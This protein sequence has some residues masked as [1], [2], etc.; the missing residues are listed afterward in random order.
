MARD[1]HTDVDAW[2]LARCGLSLRLAT[3]GDFMARVATFDADVQ[4]EHRDYAAR[5]AEAGFETR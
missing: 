3:L 5:R 1:E 2:I 4:A